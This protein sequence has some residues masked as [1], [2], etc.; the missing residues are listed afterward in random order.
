MKRVYHF[1]TVQ[2]VT[3]SLTISKKWMWYDHYSIQIWSLLIL[4]YIITKHYPENAI[5]NTT[6]ICSYGEYISQLLRYAR[7]YTGVPNLSL[8]FLQCSLYYLSIHFSEGVWY[9]TPIS[10]IFRWY[11]GGQFYWC[12][13][14]DKNIDLPQV[15]DKLITKCCIVSTSPW[16]GFEL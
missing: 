12:R 2:R 10:T 1:N 14:P 16:A 4:T 6:I 5:T 3:D 8:G 7:Y 15:T 13:T 11:R 9:L